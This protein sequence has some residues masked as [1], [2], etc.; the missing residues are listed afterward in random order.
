MHDQYRRIQKS[1]QLDSSID[2]FRFRG[3]G[4]AQSMVLRS[5]VTTVD[6]LAAHPLDHGVVLGVNHRQRAVLFCDCNTSSV[7]SEMIR[8][9]E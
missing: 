3:P 9:K 4:V 2:G 6:Q 5:A 8:W 1:G 7:G